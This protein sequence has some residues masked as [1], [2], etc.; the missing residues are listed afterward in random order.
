MK[1][2]NEQEIEGDKEILAMLKIDKIFKEYKL[3]EYDIERVLQY[4]GDKSCCTFQNGRERIL[5]RI[6]LALNKVTPADRR[7]LEGKL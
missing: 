7:E 2:N 5:Q 3:D 6:E 4:F 1:T